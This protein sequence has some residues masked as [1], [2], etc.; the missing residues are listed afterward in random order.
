MDEAAKMR[1]SEFPRSLIVDLKFAGK[2]RD[3]AEQDSCGGK[4]AGYLTDPDK[5]WSVYFWIPPDPSPYDP[6]MFP[7][8]GNRIDS[9][10]DGIR[11][12]VASPRARTFI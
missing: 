4:R 10:L 5:V 2:R 3:F 7:L 1:L 9:P 11:L 8:L 6:Q 12:D